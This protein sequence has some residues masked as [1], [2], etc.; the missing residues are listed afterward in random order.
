MSWGLGLEVCDLSGFFWSAAVKSILS[1]GFTYT[2]AVTVLSQPIPSLTTISITS[3]CVA[4]CHFSIPLQD[5]VNVMLNNT[6]FRDD[7][8][9]D[10]DTSRCGSSKHHYLYHLLCYHRPDQ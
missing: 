7:D 9:D 8:D 2:N 3:F 10:D 1:K 5:T 6:I 4:L